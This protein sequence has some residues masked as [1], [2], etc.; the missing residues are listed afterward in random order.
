[1]AICF[2]GSQ[3]LMNN[4][5]QND[6][7]STSDS[8]PIKK[9]FIYLQNSDDID[10]PH[11]NH[12][13]ASNS[14]LDS[15][16]QRY[17]REKDLDRLVMAISGTDQAE[18]LRVSSADLAIVKDL[19][20]TSASTSA[21]PFFLSTKKQ[22]EQTADEQENN[23]SNLDYIRGQHQNQHQQQQQQHKR[24]QM[25]TKQLAL[26]AEKSLNSNASPPFMQN[27]IMQLYVEPQGMQNQL[28]GMIPM[29]NQNNAHNHSQ[30]Q[31]TSKIL[32]TLTGDDNVNHQQHANFSQQQLDQRADA[33]PL[34]Q[35]HHQQI[36]LSNRL[37]SN[38]D[39]EDEQTLAND[40]TNDCITS[41]L[42]NQHHHSNDELDMDGKQSAR[43]QHLFSVFI[44]NQRV[45]GKTD[46]HA[47]C[48]RFWIRTQSQARP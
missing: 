48:F 19:E 47:Y 8:V 42:L 20:S 7:I 15:S 37:F 29:S 41:S 21:S 1:M 25:N 9:E 16:N 6:R 36:H 26:E 18:L 39:D 11:G 28:I 3:Q 23:N 14:R 24:I 45:K 31:D 12:D 46:L 13:A 38:N 43:N 33:Q 40:Q 34:I 32:N 35:H 22:L 27:P 5:S 2:F 10:Q 4:F 17:T 44:N 30:Q